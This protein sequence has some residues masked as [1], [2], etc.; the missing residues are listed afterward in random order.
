MTGSLPIRRL[1]PAVDRDHVTDLLRR[2]ADYVRLERGEEPS[3]AAAEEFFTDVPPGS[4]PAESLK[5][6]L[7]LPDGRLAGIAD[8]GFDYPEKG[9][10]FLGLIQLASEARGQG[11]G[12][13]FLRHIEAA[14]RARGATRLFIAVLDENPRG[15]AFWDREGFTVALANRPVRLGQK[16][17]VATRMVK[18]L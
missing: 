5:L 9:D 18:P 7:V 11:R 2:S 17:H 15:R 16:D 6:G 1:D 14:A 13:A 4:D 3:E 12:A 10:A 8:L